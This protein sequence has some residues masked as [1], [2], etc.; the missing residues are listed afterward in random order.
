MCVA[1]ASFLNVPEISPSRRN[2]QRAGGSLGLSRSASGPDSAGGLRLPCPLYIGMQGDAEVPMVRRRTL[3]IRVWLGRVGGLG[4]LLSA[5]WSPLLCC[6][7]WAPPP[8]AFLTLGRNFQEGISAGDTA[9]SVS[10]SPVLSG[11]SR[12]LE[13]SSGFWSPCQL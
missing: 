7:P 8:L 11:G 9:A 1:F 6:G 2:L 5:S 13:F 4:P 10:L 3:R 12:T